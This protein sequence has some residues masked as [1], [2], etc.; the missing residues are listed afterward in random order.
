MIVRATRS[1]V[2]DGTTAATAAQNAVSNASE[3]SGRGIDWRRQFAD[4]VEE[5]LPL[6]R[7]GFPLHEVALNTV[8]E[9]GQGQDVI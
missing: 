2:A 6:H 1:T 3:S 9:A 4:Q 8:R 5:F 7:E